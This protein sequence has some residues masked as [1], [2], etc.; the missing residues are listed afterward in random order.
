MASVVPTYRTNSQY[1][2]TNSI[3]TQNIFSSW[4]SSATVTI[5]HEG[6]AG[7][8]LTV[9][10]SA[11]PHKEL[12]N[13]GVLED[14]W[15]TFVFTFDD[16]CQTSKVVDTFCANTRPYLTGASIDATLDIEQLY[17]REAST[18]F[19]EYDDDDTLSYNTITNWPNWITLDTQ[20]GHIRGVQREDTDEAFTVN[21]T[22]VLGI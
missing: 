6:P 5:D 16:G 7:S 14:G 2:L 12:G 20:T 9:G 1:P 22:Y 18:L 10:N 3:Y 21:T 8:T 17:E 19:V 15:H 4:D 13:N 11:G